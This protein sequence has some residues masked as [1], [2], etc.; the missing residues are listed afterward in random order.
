MYILS[1]LLRQIHL[2]P[3]ASLSIVSAV[4]VICI[5]PCAFLELSNS[6]CPS[7][8]ELHIHLNLTTRDLAASR[9]LFF[10]IQLCCIASPLFFGSS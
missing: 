7:Q 3:F 8:P 4:L 5:L 6:K 9:I 10:S 2:F 1:M